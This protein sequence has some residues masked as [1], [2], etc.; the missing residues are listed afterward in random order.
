MNG[1]TRVMADADGIQLV[2]V[3]QGLG[4]ST[5]GTSRV[6]PPSTSTTLLTRS[7]LTRPSLT[8]SE[9]SC[10]RLCHHAEALFVRRVVRPGDSVLHGNQ[11][12]GLEAKD[13]QEETGDGEPE[14]QEEMEDP[15]TM[16]ETNPQT[17]TTSQHLLII[18]ATT[19][20]RRIGSSS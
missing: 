12:K 1:F 8:R 4:R 5:L 13:H 9:T 16:T 7:S 10:T 15:P 6:S 19:T 11:V 18:T 14:A 2:I 17:E 3:T 20:G